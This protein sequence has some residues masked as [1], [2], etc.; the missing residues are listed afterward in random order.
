MDNRLIVGLDIGTTKIDVVIGEVVDG[1]LKIVGIGT[2]PSTGLQRGVVVNIDATV[3]SINKA[4]D[5]AEIMAGKDVK[6]EVFVGVAG[7]HIASIGGKG[8]IAINN[9]NHEVGHLDVRRVIEAAQSVPMQSDRRILHV[10]PTGFKVDDQT[11]IKDPIGMWCGTRLEGDVHIVHGAATAIQN[12]ETSVERSGLIVG[13]V[14]LESLASSYAVLDEDEREIGVAVI[15]MGGG[16][17]DLAIFTDNSIRHT[18][19]IDFGGDNVTADLA[20]GIRTPKDKAEEIKKRY[21]TCRLS[22]M[23]KDQF[24]PVPGVGG[25]EGHEQS[26]AFVAKIIRA[27]MK[28]IFQFMNRDLDKSRLR[29]KLGAGIVLT[30]G[31][32][33]MDGAVELAEDVFGM[34]VKLGMPRTDGGLSDVVHSPRHVTGVG[35]VMYGLDQM[36]KRSQEKSSGS[37]GEGLLDGFG[38]VIGWLKRYF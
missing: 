6:G 24:V 8:M 27:R 19:S 14:V 1:S 13:D 18:S 36:Q 38:S 25:R 22:E 2:S 23:D 33:M 35:L 16:T 30:G 26:K 29:T 34:P 37:K 31:G 21:G 12:I 17:T 7:K 15:D 9:P 28:E 32:A 3:K 4:V 5:E 11:G 20:I 10:I